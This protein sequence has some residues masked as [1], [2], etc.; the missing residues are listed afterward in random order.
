MKL[1]AL[2]PMLRT[3]ELQASI[4]FYTE[5]LGFKCESSQGR[6]CRRQTRYCYTQPGAPGPS[7]LGTTGSTKSLETSL[8]SL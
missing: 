1:E 7:L 8:N 3:W 6:E 2:N 4:R 5:I